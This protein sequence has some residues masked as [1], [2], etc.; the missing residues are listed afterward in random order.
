MATALPTYGLG[1]ERA[2]CRA[3]N[4]GQLDRS[5]ARWYSQ[6]MRPTLLVAV[7]AA[8]LACGHG[9]VAPAASPVAPAPAA[10][11]APAS[12]IESGPPAWPERLAGVMAAHGTPHVQ[13]LALPAGAP[14]ERWLA[15]VGD[16]ASSLG[17]WRVSGS[18]GT[19]EARPVAAWP[20]ATRVV[21]GLVDGG[22]GYVLL[23]TVA[24]LDQPAGL[25]GVWIEPGAVPSPFEGAPLGLAGVKDLDELTTRLHTAQPGATPERNTMALMATLRAAA[26][27]AVALSRSLAAEGADVG[28]VW[29]GLFVQT[30]AHLDGQGATPSPAS[31]HALALLKGM[32]DD[33]ACSADACQAWTEGGRAIVRFVVQGGRWLIRSI[34]ED[35]APPPRT[36]SAAHRTVD[37]SADTRATTELLAAR[38]GHVDRVV[39]E[40]PLGDH[41]G[42]IGVALADVAPDVPLVVVREGGASRLFPLDLV[43]ARK[44]AGHASWDAAFAD[45]DGDGRT[46]VVVRRTTDASGDP[47]GPAPSPAW[48]Q[49]FLAPPPTVQPV[50]LDPD[51]AS[52][53]AV[54]D[55]PDAA[56]AARLA[57]ALPARTVTREEACKVLAA[58]SSPAG[59]R[60]LASADARVLRF[61]QPGLPTWRPKI[62]ASSKVTSD[63]VR[64]LGAHCAELAC[65]AARPYCGWTGGADSQHF[66]FDGHPGPLS[67]LGAADY[68]GE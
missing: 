54:M 50:R 21:G 41:G 35:A 5:A 22:A 19:L 62:V 67:L 15:F 18:S 63:D 2:R 52:S 58:A 47:P 40:A 10:S 44:G 8:C 24:A 59:F 65:D 37:A 7:G 12:A 3:A 48:T 23:E 36:P 14:G 38:A 30:T 26:P 57:S 32:L 29:Q 64:G 27:S 56:A 11:V 39:A 25:R 55:A 51:L 16:A 68:E 34:L 9:D 61:D 4:A 6:P 53:L 46:D 20:T 42:S 1:P 33:A 49:V 45:V 28:V 31:D 13:P 43:T 66:W 60:R 17:A